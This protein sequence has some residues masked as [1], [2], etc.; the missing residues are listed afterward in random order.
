MDNTFRFEHLMLIVSI[1]IML[2]I[3]AVSNSYNGHQG[4]REKIKDAII[5]NPNITCIEYLKMEE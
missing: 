2:F 5:N 1:F 3:V 4:E